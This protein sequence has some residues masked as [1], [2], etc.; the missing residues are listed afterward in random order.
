MQTEVFRGNYFF[1]D[2]INREI[3][4]KGYTVKND[5][6]CE[7]WGTIQINFKN[8][9]EKLIILKSNYNSVNR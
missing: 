3:E 8:L 2:F 9:D 5:M 4:L 1:P 6:L 7:A